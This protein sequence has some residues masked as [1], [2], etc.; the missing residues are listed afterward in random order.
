MKICIITCQNAV[1]HGARLQC[2][3]LTHWLQKR[4][5]DVEVIDY[6]PAYSLNSPLW[7]WPGL[8]LKEWVKLPLQYN[9][10][11][12]NI[13]RRN[14]FDAFSRKYIP[15][16]N[17]KYFSI[18][19]LK[20]SPPD[21]DVYLAG[22]DQIWNTTLANGTDPAYYLDFGPDNVRRESFA[23][24]FATE[25][26]KPGTELFVKEQLEKFNK[27][28]VREQSSLRILDSLG[29][30]GSHQEDPVFLLSASDW[31]KIADGTG[32]R[33]R[34]VLVYDFYLGDDIKKEALIVAKDKNLKIYNISHSSLSYAD[35][36]FVYAGPETFVSLV[37]HA[38]FVVSNSF[39][40]TAFAMLYGVPYKVL[41]RPDGLNI[42]M[43]DL[44]ERHGYSN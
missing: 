2:Y 43:H 12:K 40:G 25:Q 44:L 31:D 29:L 37:K 5:N 17:R 23:A 32:A 16:T 15:L 7:Y 39:H 27:I 11:K 26:L 14:V 10:R 18:E 19:D 20:N 36:N 35:K 30:K 13:E 4:G 38:S 41:D 24:S 9:Y 3:A 6:R 42:R 8:S 28:T 34:Y 33:E 21:A 22:S 1:N